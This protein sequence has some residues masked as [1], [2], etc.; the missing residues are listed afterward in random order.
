MKDSSY[1]PG[2]DEAVVLA[3]SSEPEVALQLENVTLMTPHNVYHVVQTCLVEGLSLKMPK[4]DTMLIAG[5]SGV[6]KSSLVRS[7]AGLWRQ[8]KGYIRHAP[9]QNVYFIPQRPYLCIGS[10][11]EQLVYPR[12]TVEDS[13]SR[14]QVALH[15]VGLQGLL[16][17]VGL[18]TSR[19]ETEGADF[20]DTNNEWLSKISLGE[21]QRLSFARLLLREDIQLMVLDE[22]TSAMSPDD[23][24]QMYALM[25]ECCSSYVSVAH[26]PQLRQFHQTALVL[27]AGPVIDG[28]PSPASYRI[29]PMEK[30]EQELGSATLTT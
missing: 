7:M 3:K 4:G 1:R 14:L 9:G 15:R 13:D 22:A 11:R 12:S 26:R 24:A 16:E 28:C 27:Q 29:L 8:G 20:V 5:E 30:Y 17:R 21:C 23:E 25:K 10:L 2:P 18:G 6:G 19:D